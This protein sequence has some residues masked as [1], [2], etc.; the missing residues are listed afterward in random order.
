MQDH[1]N[2]RDEG[3]GS[4]NDRPGRVRKYTTKCLLWVLKKRAISSSEARTRKAFLAEETA[5][6]QVAKM[7]E[8]IGIDGGEGNLGLL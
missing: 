3:F 5:G 4:G 7:T 1:T 2:N 8:A 6:T